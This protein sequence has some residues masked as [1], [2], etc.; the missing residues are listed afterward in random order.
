MPRHTQRKIYKNTSRNENGSAGPFSG[1]ML[2]MFVQTEYAQELG[3]PCV[4]GTE[5]NPLSCVSTTWLDVLAL[6]TLA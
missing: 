5:E 4:G 3:D 1:L 6:S 2:Q